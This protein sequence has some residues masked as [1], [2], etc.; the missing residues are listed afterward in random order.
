MSFSVEILSV[1]SELA[2]AASLAIGRW[3]TSFLPS[4]PESKFRSVPTTLKLIAPSFPCVEV[5]A[6]HLAFLRRMRLRS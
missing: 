5:F 1:V 4:D 6:G 2:I 3:T